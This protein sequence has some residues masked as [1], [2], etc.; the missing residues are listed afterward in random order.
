MIYQGLRF[1]SS[2]TRL[3]VPGT[4]WATLS[5]IAVAYIVRRLSMFAGTSFVTLGL[6]QAPGQDLYPPVPNIKA[7]ALHPPKKSCPHIAYV[8]CAFS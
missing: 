6:S 4:N 8:P 2:R 1:G 5:T 3:Q 7:P